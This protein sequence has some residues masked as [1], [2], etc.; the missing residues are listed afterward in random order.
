MTDKVTD[1]K[2]NKERKREKKK[3]RSEKQEALELQTE[4]TFHATFSPHR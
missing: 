4:G 2:Q 1:A 3:E